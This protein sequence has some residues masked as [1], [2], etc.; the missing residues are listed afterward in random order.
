MKVKPSELQQI[1]EAALFSSS[2]ALSVSQLVKLVDGTT[3]TAVR[4]AV[5]MLNQDY[6]MTH[7]V[8]RI[9]PVAGGFQLRTLPR[10][11]QWIQKV[12]TLRPTKLSLSVI[13]TLAIVAYRQP[14]TRA[15]IE[16]I[17]GVDSSYTLRT[18]IE[19]KMIK[20]LGREEVPGRPSL[21]GTSSFFLEVFGLKDLKYLP[22]LSELQQPDLPFQ[23][24]NDDD[25][26]PD[27]EIVIN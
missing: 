25:F 15:S 6:E 26:L 11:K 21:Y 4:K 19:K 17:R 16:G 3:A 7:R 13:E 12:E 22:S 10:Y 2:R 5:E 27:G 18:L 8:F 14:V 1:L 20:I 23:A 9:E 24:S